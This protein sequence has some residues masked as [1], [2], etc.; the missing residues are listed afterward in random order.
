MKKLLVG[1]TALLTT[2]TG[3]VAGVSPAEAAPFTGGHAAAATHAGGGYRGGGGYGYR[4]GGYG[5]RGGYGGPV[6]AG[7]AGLAVGAAIAGS[8]PYYGPGYYYGAPAPYYAGPGYYGYYGCHRVLT[9][10]GYR[11]VGPCY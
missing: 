7:L 5:Y 10:W 6:V 8:Y 2:L 1:A 9:R 11:A 3:A 4:G